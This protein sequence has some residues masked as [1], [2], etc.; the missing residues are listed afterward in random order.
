M[1]NLLVLALVGTIA[2]PAF[3]KEAPKY[4]ESVPK[5]TISELPYGTH[6]R[7]VLDFWKAESDKPTPLILVIHGGGWNGGSKERLRRPLGSMKRSG[8]HLRRGDQLPLRT[9]GGQCW[10]QA[11]CKST[12]GGRVR[13]LQF[14]R[15]KA[16]EWNLDKER[17]AQRVDLQEPARVC[18]WL[19]MT[20]SPIPRTLIL[21]AR[22][23]SPLVC[24]RHRGTDYFGPKAD[25]GVDTKQQIRRPCL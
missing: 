1:K 16:T 25:E 8:R 20:I 13:A 10:N 7:Q 23:N 5:P 9:S 12:A 11:T 18:G 6:K 4:A 19:F 21:S 2:I 3:S 14:I 24:G 22:V 15:S 17:I